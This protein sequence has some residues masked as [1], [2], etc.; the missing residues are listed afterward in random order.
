MKPSEPIIY[1]RCKILFLKLLAITL[2]I[3]LLTANQKDRDIPSSAAP[4]AIKFRRV[5]Q[6]CVEQTIVVNYLLHA[7]KRER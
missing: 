2:T 3:Q 5:E 4:L 6:T 7:E 1:F